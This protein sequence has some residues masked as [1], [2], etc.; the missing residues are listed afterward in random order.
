MIDVG[1]PLLVKISPELAKVRA[2][3][4]FWLSM[5]SSCLY[6]KAGIRGTRAEGELQST[7]I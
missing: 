4:R 2:R 7:E 6:P 5:V 1:R 3:A